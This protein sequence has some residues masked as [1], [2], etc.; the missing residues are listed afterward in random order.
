MNFSDPSGLCPW[1]DIACLN[2]LVGQ[3]QFVSNMFFLF[4]ASSVDENAKHAAAGSRAA[5]VFL[6]IDIGSNAVPAGGEGKAALSALIRDAT[7][8]PNA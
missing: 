3:A 2:D 1:H 5:A 7:E 6:V 8:H 4:G